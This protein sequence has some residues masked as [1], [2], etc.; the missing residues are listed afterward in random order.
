MSD[1]IP[2]EIQPEVIKRVHPVKSLI[3][4]GSVC[5]QWKSLIDSPEFITHHLLVNTQPHR[6]LIRHSLAFKVECVSIVDDDVTTFP[7]HTFYPTVPPIATTK[8][9]QDSSHGLV[10]FDREPSN[11][12]VVWNPSIRK[13]VG[14]MSPV[15]TYIAGFGV[16]PSTSDVKI[17]AIKTDSTAEVF[18]LTT[19]IWRR[20]PMNLFSTCKSIIFTYNQVVVDG[21]VHWAACA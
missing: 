12:I 20:I 1:N 9:M 14:I 3:R 11:F 7:E 17:V 10:C 13:S 4:F 21:V 8:L 2:F 19:R 18:T 16:C 6:L 15:D 5:K